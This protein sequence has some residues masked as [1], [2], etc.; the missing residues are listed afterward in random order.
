MTDQRCLTSAIA[1]RS[2]LTAGQSSSST[3]HYVTLS[4]QLTL[5]GII[6]KCLL[7]LNAVLVGASCSGQQAANLAFSYVILFNFK[8]SK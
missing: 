2:A 3:L 1:R 8:Q 5:K 4:S 6:L 7:H